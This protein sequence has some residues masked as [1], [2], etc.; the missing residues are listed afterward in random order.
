MTCLTRVIAGIHYPGDIVVG[1]FL[2]W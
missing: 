2:G 1:F